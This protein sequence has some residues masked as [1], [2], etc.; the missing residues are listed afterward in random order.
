MNE[1]GKDD[2]VQSVSSGFV[3]VELA[4]VLAHSA[5]LTSEIEEVIAVQSDGSSIVDGDT[6]MK[7]QKLDMVRQLQGDIANI[8]EEMSRSKSDQKISGDELHQLIAE[9]KLG[10]VRNALAS[11]LD[12]NCTKPAFV[13][14]Q[15]SQGGSLDLF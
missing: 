15:A 4:N 6:I 9:S 1:T 13:E 11:C 8:L 10:L 7:L 14:E 3:L 5:E 2:S 12:E